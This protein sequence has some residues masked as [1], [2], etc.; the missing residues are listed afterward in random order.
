M[1]RAERAVENRTEKQEKKGKAKEHKDVYFIAKQGADES[2]KR[3][4]KKLIK[5]G[6]EILHHRFIKPT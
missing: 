3:S 5:E 4:E 2:D 6:K 1:G